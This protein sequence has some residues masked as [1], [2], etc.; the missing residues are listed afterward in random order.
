MGSSADLLLHPV[1]L[2]VVQALAGGRRLSA[3]ELATELVDVPQ[4]SLYRHIARLADAGVLAVV[5]ERPAR[6]T[7]ERVYALVDSAASLSGE[8]LA[9]AGREDHLRYFTVFLSGLIDDFG[10]YLDAGDPDFAA[11]GVGYR[12]VPLE[13]TDQEFAELAGRLNAA[14]APVIG[15]R[16]GPG[17]RR[18]MLTT[19]VMPAGARA[20]HPV[21]Q[22]NPA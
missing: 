21:T 22:E 13:L 4:A 8:D 10:R 2:R 19:V 9:H 14:L 7:A 20:E 3:G 16:P 12:Q 17:R 18:R 5:A 1:R 11:D 15:N 6:G